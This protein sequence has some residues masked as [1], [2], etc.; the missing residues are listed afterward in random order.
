MNTCKFCGCL[1]NENATV[2]EKCEKEIQ[3]LID[4]DEQISKINTNY[5]VAGMMTAFF[6]WLSM[7]SIAMI[8]CTLQHNWSDTIG[9]ISLFMLMV[10][11][12]IFIILCIVRPIIGRKIIRLA[13]SK[14]NKK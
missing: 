4:N 6:G 11:L 7:I 10:S 13:E 5:A 9:I 14:I 2:C 3:N 1:I 12:P 8:Y